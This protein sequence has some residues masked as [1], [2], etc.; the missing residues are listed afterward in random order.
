LKHN[1]GVNRVDNLS[2][3]IEAASN[4]AFDFELNLA[5]GESKQVPVWPILTRMISRITCL[6]FAGRSVTEVP[7]FV[8]SMASFTRKIIIAGTFLAL[9]PRWLGDRVVRRFLSLEYEIDLILTHF[10]PRLEGHLAQTNA[11][12]DEMTY[13][14]WLLAL[15]KHDGTFRT[16]RESAYQFKDVVLASIHTTSHF[17]TFALHELACRPALVQALRDEIGPA[18]FSP[19]TI[20]TLPLL[21]SFLREVLRCDVDYL[22]LHHKAMRDVVM[23][24]G[25][26]IPKG[27]LVFLALDDANRVDNDVFDP[28]RFVN[29]DLEQKS[30]TLT[31]DF[32]TFGAGPHACPGRHFAIM[33]IKY[34][35]AKFV[36]RYNIKSTQPN[37]IRAPDSLVMGMTR[38]PPQDPIL[39]EGR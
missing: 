13:G 18:E 37:G 16:P 1:L 7:G 4:E 9:L 19:L 14:A 15:P 17:L 33:E 24:N 29:M 28:Y 36:T 34:N 12:G 32:M 27:T 10:T 8:E 22:G 5:P 35:I 25:Q 21:D 3:R 31:Q 39:F 2:D 26:C 30:A 6:C 23:S 20:N 11:A 38:N